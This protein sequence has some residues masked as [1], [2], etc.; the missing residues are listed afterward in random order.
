MMGLAERVAGLPDRGDF[1]KRVIMNFSHSTRRRIRVA[2]ALVMLYTVTGFFILPPI[3]KA[4]L[5]QRL[6]AALGRR[7]TVGKVRVNPYALS[8]TLENFAVR[9]PDGTAVFLGWRRLYVNFG[10]WSSLW[11]EWVLGEVALDGFK[12]RVVVNPD[13]SMNF[14]DVLAKFTPV[15]GPAA[16][17]TQPGRPVRIASLKVS[18]SQID[19]ADLSRKQRF[20]TTIGPLD[21]A[22]TDFRTA[23]GPGAPY[24]FEAS[25]ESGEK[26]SWSGTLQ[27]A[28][29]RSVGEL[30]LQNILLPKYAPYYADQ[31]QADLAGGTL[32]VHGHY[33]VSLGKGLEVLQL[34]DGSMKLRG[35]KLQERASHE[36]AFELPALD[37]DGVQVD[38][39]ARKATVRSVALAGGHVRVR[40]EKGGAINLLAML[41]PPAAT[42]PATAAPA[43]G[44]ARLPDVT[45]GELT[46]TDFQA[47]V[48]DLA[49]PRPVQLALSGIQMSLKNISLAEGA[50][51]P[52]Q[53]AFAW[54]PGGTVRI[55][56]NMGIKPV[57]AD[58]KTE[59]AGFEIPPLGPYLESFANLHI[60]QGALT[61]TLATQVSLTDGKP[62]TA[63]VAGDL[64]VDHFSLV[65]A[66][67]RKKLAGFGG[68]ALRGLHI[69]TAPE[70]SVAIDEVDV[71]GPYA[72]IIVGQDKL[73]NLATV[74]IRPGAAPAP[75]PSGAAVPAATP[76]VASPPP[77]I[78]IGKIVVTDGDFRFTDHSVE[79]NVS[80]AIGQFGGTVTGLSPAGPAKAEVNLTAMVDGI[81]SVAVTGKID[82]LG[83]TKSVDLKVDFKNVDLLP[84]DPYC[85]KYAGYELARGKLDLDVKLLMAGS[86]INSADVITLNQFTFGQ[87][88]KSAEAT[89]LPVRLGVALLKDIDG[90]IVIDVPV[91]GSTAD[92]SFRVGRVV[93]RVIVNLL[94]K[95][96]V[97]PFSLLGAAFGGG[98][99]ELA[100]QEF[101]PGSS[102][103]QPGEIRKLQTMVQALT[104]R[105]GLSLGLEGSYDAATD[106]AALK[107]LKLTD[108]IRRQVWEPKQLAD[109]NF[110][111][112]AQMVITPEESAAAIKQLFDQKF[113]PGAPLPAIVAPP[114]SDGLIQHIVSVITLKDLREK[115][116]A[117]QEIPRPVP[118][119][120]VPVEEMSRRLTDAIT[121]DDNDLR[122]LARARAQQVRDY[123]ATTGRIA[124][125][126]LF[127]ANATTTAVGNAAKAG[128]GPRVF[129]Q[130]Q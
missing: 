13:Q 123:F 24:R 64:K 55:K 15:Q 112:L 18:E 90:K 69:S 33:E 67:R 113:P 29:L 84:L 125:D 25:T 3:L 7:V 68:F 80:M 59:I 119:A 5:E 27:A 81:G 124:A 126:R 42:P 58:L 11:G 32:S 118:A 117:Q 37:I 100:Y 17:P 49:P 30:S 101:A 114:A 87:P 16:P 110:P 51:M 115:H 95:A 9:E 93:L 45:V 36:T 8:L 99:D 39:V 57:K 97:S 23:S 70:L 60:T 53:L 40:R 94:T 83:V 28:P 102:A 31:M 121:I 75:T 44:P 96:A 14:S 111:P 98:G 26:L 65:D 86:Q 77:K 82:P 127:L 10:A 46:L 47:E 108:Q 6:S 91:Q 105:P 104:N 76:T 85:E 43:A 129:L 41:Q 106:A 128:K 52:L 4:Q 130:L 74:V 103:I 116:S 38:A 79:P 48:S 72:R 1:C 20:T 2:A 66:A 50:Q 61:A 22:I 19:F 120:S 107:Q 35:L 73:V 63:T 56:G 62:L 122:A 89:S 78:E 12:A 34:V 54:A 109:P 71:T 21:F 88:V 92:P